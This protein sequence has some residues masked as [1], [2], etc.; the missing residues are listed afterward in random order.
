MVLAARPDARVETIEGPH[1]LLQREP[2]KAAA[3]IMKF[4]DQIEP[5]V[6]GGS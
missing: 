4:I 6:Q 2:Q 1:L 5:A 3:V